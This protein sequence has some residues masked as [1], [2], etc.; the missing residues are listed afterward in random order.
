M[1]SLADLPELAGFFSYSRQDDKHSQGALSGL[2]TLIQSELRLQLGR[3]FRLW[4]DTA[5]ISEGALWEDEIDRAIAESVFFIPIVTP[6]SVGS[7]HCK[8]E[9]ES[10]LKR[11]AA[12]GRKDLIFPIL[13]VTVDALETEAQWRQ[14]ELLKIIGARQYLDWRM[15]RYYEYNLPEVRQKIGQFGQ[16]IAKALHKR[17]VM[18]TP[19]Q[20]QEESKAAEQREASIVGQVPDPHHVAESSRNGEAVADNKNEIEPRR[21]AGENGRQNGSARQHGAHESVAATKPWQQGGPLRSRAAIVVAGVIAVAI[22]GAFAMWKAQ[23]PAEIPNASPV[24]A[25]IPPPP[26]ERPPVAAPTP[27]PVPPPIERAPVVAPTPAPTPAPAPSSPPP[28]ASPDFTRPPPPRPLLLNSS[29]GRWAVGEQSNCQVPS[30]FYTLSSSGGNIVWRSGSGGVD[31]EAIVS[32]GESEFR[33]RTVSSIHQSG[34][35]EATGTSWVYTRAGPD[36]IQVTRDG[37]SAFMLA[38]CS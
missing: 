23:P 24:P 35:G 12:L 1:S 17:W 33:T 2:R 18:P 31:T 32:S 8:F 6:S 10:F 13:Y 11:E 26:I 22:V 7:S 36:R 3:D 38:R 14:D 21:G 9:F 25:R 37:R 19:S 28:A 5:A 34:S 16:N 30:K 27:A 20:T 4:Q 29:L 15:L